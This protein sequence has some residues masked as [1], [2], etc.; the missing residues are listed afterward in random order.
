MRLD[1]ISFGYT[2]GVRV[3]NNVSFEISDRC[4]N[5]LL[6]HNGAGKTT[7]LRI[8]GGVLQPTEGELHFEGSGSPDSVG[9]MPEVGGVYENLTGLQNML[10]RCRVVGMGK[11][12]AQAACDRQVAALGMDGFVDS[13]VARYSFGQKRRL[14]L[15]C[16][17]LSD[18]S[19]LLLDEP[20]NGLDPETRVIVLKILQQHQSQGATVVVASHDLNMIAEIC[21]Y[22]TLLHKGDVR[23]KGP[24]AT[25]CPVYD[26]YIDNTRDEEG[27][28]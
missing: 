16:A 11:Q 17:L 25:D 13:F 23:F 14:A 1:A 22:V 21:P 26:W 7:L 10:F 2:R 24:M 8:L 3:L 18:P 28:S 5:G 27:V 19:L 4:I 9:Y 12:A 20:T 15:A 6:G